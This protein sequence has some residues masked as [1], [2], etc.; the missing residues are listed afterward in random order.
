VIEK[1][2]TMPLHVE[3]VSQERKLFE[4]KAADMVIA[5]GLEGVLGILPNHSPLISLLKNG[6]LVIRKGNAEE[7]FAVYGGV[8]DVRPDKVVVLADS[9]DFAADLSVRAAEEARERVLKIIAEGV[10]P[11]D[12]AFIAQQLKRAEFAMDVARK[13]TGRQTVGIRIVDHKKDQND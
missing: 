7:I 4:E 10:P 6:E 3:V 12:E 5:P 13:H 11:E 9:A 1:D 8:L 2:E